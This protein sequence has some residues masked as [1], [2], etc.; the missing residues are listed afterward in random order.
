MHREIARRHVNTN[1]I[2]TIATLL[3]N[4]AY[5]V[6]VGIGDHGQP[7][8]C[9][10]AVIDAT[11]NILHVHIGEVSIIIGTDQSGGCYFGI[12]TAES[13]RAWIITRATNLQASHLIRITPQRINIDAKPREW[14]LHLLPIVRYCSILSP[15]IHIPEVLC[16]SKSG[17][18]LRKYRMHAI[19][20]NK[21]HIAV[22][23]RHI[24]CSCITM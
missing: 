12:Q 23:S 14:K 9:L 8:H 4:A 17:T 2:P 5:Q 21:R 6:T 3:H 7:A 1:I 18:Y 19:T 22:N 10:A 13:D 24:M 15:E 11:A 16:M 20:A